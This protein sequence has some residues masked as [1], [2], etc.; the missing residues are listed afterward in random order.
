MFAFLV[1][2]SR[3]LFYDST[4]TSLQMLHVVLGLWQVTNYLLNSNLSSFG[5]CLLNFF[6]K[7]LQNG[8][9]YNF[10][11]STPADKKNKSSK[12]NGFI[13]IGRRKVA[14]CASRSNQDPI[15]AKGISRYGH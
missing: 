6:C 14:T 10:S 13:N 8:I 7:S 9:P 4:Q 1:F 3:L 12:S 15:M 5:P 11:T 2:I